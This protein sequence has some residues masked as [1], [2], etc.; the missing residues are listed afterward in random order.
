MEIAKKPGWLQPLL[1]K[2]TGGFT[3]IEIIMSIALIAIGILG[4]SLN[5]IGII[6]GNFISGNYTIATSL[7]QDKMEELLG[8]T[9]FTNVDNCT[10]PPDQDI[11]A[12][13]GTG[14]IYDRCWEIDDPSPSLGAN[15]KQI[16]VTVK[17]Q[18]YLNRTVT[19]STLVY[20]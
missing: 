7:A 5:S 1:I 4:F 15:L 11:T 3:L 9:S 19:L 17:W 6:Q 13:G 2:R 10:N 18:D 16:D 8:E 12:T 20:T 14:G